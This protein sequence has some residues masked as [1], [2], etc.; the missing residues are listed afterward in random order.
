MFYVEA[1]I[2]SGEMPESCRDCYM[3][4]DDGFGGWDC[5]VCE[6]PDD[7]DIDF[8]ARPVNCPLELKDDNG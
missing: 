1:V 8:G 4:F 5:S 2:I 3:P 6:V 7:F